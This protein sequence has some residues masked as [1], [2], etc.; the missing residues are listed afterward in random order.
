MKM[1]IVSKRTLA[2]LRKYDRTSKGIKQLYAEKSKLPALKQR[3][4]NVEINDIRKRYNKNVKSFLK[5][6]ENKLIVKE[7][8]K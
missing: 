7:P 3:K 1:P 2:M 5:L 8:P 4:I 6:I